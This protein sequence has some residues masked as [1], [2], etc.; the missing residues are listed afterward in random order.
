MIVD[1]IV[2]NKI[3]TNKEQ[4]WWY[5]N[6]TLPYR[7]LYVLS[8]RIHPV[9]KSPKLFV[10]H[11]C[12]IDESTASIYRYLIGIQQEMEKKMNYYVD[13]WPGAGFLRQWSPP[14]RRK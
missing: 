9:K 3:L 14:Y 10:Q 2:L 5:P 11:Y 6:V 12:Y 4:K 13:Q 1:M 8:P 7:Y